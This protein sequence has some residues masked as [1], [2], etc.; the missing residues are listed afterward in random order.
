MRQRVVVGSIV[1]AACVAVFALQGCGSAVKASEFESFH[2]SVSSLK[3]HA[4]QV[5]DQAVDWA[6]EGHIAGQE[7]GG[8]PTFAQLMLEIDDENAFAVSQ[9]HRPFYRQVEALQ[10]G[11]YELNQGMTD[12]AAQLALLAGG[13]P[14]DQARIEALAGSLKVNL[15]SSWTRI[16][17]VVGVDAAAVPEEAS[18]FFATAMAAALEFHVE[19]QRRRA[20]K[21]VLDAGQSVVVDWVDH[22]RE[23]IGVVAS[24]IGV[25]YSMWARDLGNNHVQ[26]QRERS[27]LD[28]VATRSPDESRRLDELRTMITADFEALTVRNDAVRQAL[29]ALGRIDAALER[30]PAAHRSLR[31]NLD[32]RPG[33]IDAL[34]DFYDEVRRVEQIYRRLNKTTT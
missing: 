25:T 6:R 27:R 26:R 29:D 31:E 4:D 5:L 7:V 14:Q 1:I 9:A 15:D 13:R 21:R 23:A 34:R 2:G 24:D 19:R 32:E 11:L 16:A 10:T 17:D 22:A 33:L 28:A 30:L 12:Y 18:G 8:Q 20:V 3:S